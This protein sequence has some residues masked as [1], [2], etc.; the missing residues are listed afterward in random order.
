MTCPVCGEKTTVS[1]TRNFGDH[2]VRRRKC[3]SC[4]RI[5][6]TE[7]ADSKIAEAEYLRYHDNRRE[8]LR[9]ERRRD[10]SDPLL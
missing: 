3:L 6:F 1:E 9:K 10:L 8:S 2:V 4:A 5:F 7:E